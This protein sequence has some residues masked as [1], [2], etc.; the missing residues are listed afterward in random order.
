MQ[1]QYYY[2][3]PRPPR[4]F[5]PTPRSLHR[6]ISATTLD[7]PSLLDLAPPCYNNTR[8]PR[9]TSSTSSDHPDLAPRSRPRSRKASNTYL[10]L[11]RPSST[12]EPLFS[13][14]PQRAPE[15]KYSIKSQ[16]KFFTKEPQGEFTS[17]EPCDGGFFDEQ[18]SVETHG[19]YTFFD[20]S[21][22]KLITQ[23]L[24]DE[25]LTAMKGSRN[26]SRRRGSSGK[27]F[28]D[29]D[30]Q[31]LTDEIVIAMNTGRGGKRRSKLYSF[32]QLECC[33]DS[34][35]YNSIAVSSDR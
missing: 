11:T 25:I 2:S 29:S 5:D 14:Y 23:T 9:K 3:L 17:N 6:A 21:D 34:D 33:S 16:E 1:P 30:A 13:N 28:D 12:I 22:A 27:F 19:K 31:T 4:P 8:R 35:S 24:T 20:D 18:H 32:S 15:G 7:P 26:V 10:D